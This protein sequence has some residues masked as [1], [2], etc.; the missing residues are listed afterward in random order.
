MFDKYG[1]VSH[2]RGAR[3][4]AL[5]MMTRAAQRALSA[6]TNSDRWLTCLAALHDFDATSPSASRAVRDR[7]AARLISCSQPGGGAWLTRLP[8]ASLRWRTAAS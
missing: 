2:G 3:A 8:D 5:I 6:V 4:H 1:P 7:E